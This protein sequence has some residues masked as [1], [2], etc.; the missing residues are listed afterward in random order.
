MAVTGIAAALAGPLVLGSQGRPCFPCRI[1][2]SPATPHGFKDA[3][4][5]ANGLR[6]V[7]RSHPGPLVGLATGEASGTDTL[8]LD[9]EYPEAAACSWTFRSRKPGC[10]RSVRPLA[11]GYKSDYI[12][13][14]KCRSAVA[15]A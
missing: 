9:R 6:D 2:K 5:D 1:D 11:S 15:G 8:D 4:C 14:T 13:F 12:E 10:S 7:W 3:T